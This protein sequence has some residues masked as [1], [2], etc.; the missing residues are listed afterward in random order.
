[1]PAHRNGPKAKWSFFPAFLA[2]SRYMPYIPP[3]T[4][5]KNIASSVFCQPRNSPAAAISLMSPPPNA[6]S[7][8]RQSRNIG[9]LTQSAPM[10]CGSQSA[11]ESSTLTAPKTASARFSR[12]GMV[13]VSASMSETLSKIPADRQRQQ[14]GPAHAE[15]PARQGVGSAVP[16][17]A[18]QRQHAAQKFHQQIPRRNVRTA[19]AAPPAQE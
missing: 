12:S 4:M 8:T 1:M 13:C 11:G 6:P 14:R 15:Q 17:S 5:P 7:M 19:V 9:T 16:P 3:K 18:A 2:A 10:T